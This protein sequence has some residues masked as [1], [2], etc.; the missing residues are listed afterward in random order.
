MAHREFRTADG[1]DWAVWSVNPEYA[2][3][4]TAEAT[5]SAQRTAERRSSTN[6]RVPLSGAFSNGWL[7]FETNGEKRRLAPVP[8][9]WAR[10]SDA[11]LIELCE[12]AARVEHTARRLVE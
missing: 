5:G 9:S 11:G 8:E 3:R 7:C 1:R 12:R 4:R 2:E 10:L 6:Y